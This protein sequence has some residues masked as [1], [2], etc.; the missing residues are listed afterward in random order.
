M[1]TVEIAAAFT[2]YPNGKKREFAAGEKPE[3]AN[4]YAVLL[5]RKGL[6]RESSSK[7]AKRPASRRMRTKAATPDTVTVEPT[8]PVADETHELKTSEQE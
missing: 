7:S 8:V 3:L 5:I 2:G 6:A 1:K 4:D